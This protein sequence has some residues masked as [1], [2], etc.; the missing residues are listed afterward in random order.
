MFENTNRDLTVES[1]QIFISLKTEF[2]IKIKNSVSPIALI[3]QEQ[4]RLEDLKDDIDYC[5]VINNFSLYPFYKF[6]WDMAVN[7]EFTVNNDLFH[8]F[9]SALDK[10]FNENWTN[11]DIELIFREIG[12]E[13]VISGIANARY[14]YWLE[15]FK[16]DKLMSNSDESNSH[17]EPESIALR[18]SILLMYELG[19]IEHLEEE[20]KIRGIRLAN[21]NRNYLPNLLSILMNLSERSKKETLRKEIS[22]HNNIEVPEKSLN[23]LLA[24]FG[25]NVKNPRNN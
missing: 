25:L 2:E 15:D 23:Q 10:V 20:L 14:Y 24:P 11:D 17:Q 16:D 9:P 7:G 22:K 18:H 8:R 4:K 1:N 5:L 6:G 13:E 19:I 21:E 12:I 3:Y